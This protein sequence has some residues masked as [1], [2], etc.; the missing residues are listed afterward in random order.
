MLVFSYNAGICLF[1]KQ[2]QSQ[3]DIPNLNKQL[4]KAYS[5]MGSVGSDL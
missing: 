1:T 3:G 2:K 5:K 4:D